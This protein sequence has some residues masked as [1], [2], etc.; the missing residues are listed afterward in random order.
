[1]KV[2]DSKHCII[3][4]IYILSFFPFS[5]KVFSQNPD[6]SCIQSYHGKIQ[7]MNNYLA[8]KLNI[9]NDM[10]GFAVRSDNNYFDIQP[11][12]SL[13]CKI[14]IN[15]LFISLSAK[16]APKFL[17]GNDDDEL[18]GKTKV[19]SY[20]LNLFFDHFTQSLSYTNFKGFYLHNTSDYIIDWIKNED[21]YILFPELYY[22]G[23]HGYTGYKF[24]PEFSLKALGVQTERQIEN[25][26][27]F[28]PLLYYSYY[29]VDNKA[30]LTGQNSSQK[31]NNLE[32]IIS[33]SY[34]Y[35]FSIEKNFYLSIGI[36]PGAGIIR[37]KLLTR[38]PSGNYTN[39]YRN[40]V[41]RL[42]SQLAIGYNSQRVFIG[43]Q[44]VASWSTYD[45]NKTSTIIVNNRLTYQIFLGYRFNAPNVLKNFG[46]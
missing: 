10:E 36:V 43:S 14:S 38:L 24:N 41:Y 45:Q 3:S 13:A 22:N 9:N 44:I 29:I 26:G 33:T 6:S 18:K 27:S 35:T 1:M 28:I 17:P 21:S 46:R 40:P 20:T 23:F 4:I 39:I 12:T 30:E 25:A 42:E 32:L 11:N 16:I 19:Q 8:V 34:Y 2:P 7:K 37:T 5:N 31:T 15:Y